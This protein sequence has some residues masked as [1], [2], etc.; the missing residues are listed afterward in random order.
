MAPLTEFDFHAQRQHR[1]AWLYGHGDESGI[2]LP[3]SSADKAFSRSTAAIP[4]LEPLDSGAISFAGG[5]AQRRRRAWPPRS[6][7]ALLT[8]FD[9]TLNGNLSLLGFTATVAKKTWDCL[10]SPPV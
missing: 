9:F 5:F 7:M 2:V 6:R 1:S 4:D 8:E 3:T 10:T